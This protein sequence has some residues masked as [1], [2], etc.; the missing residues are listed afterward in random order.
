VIRTLRIALVY[1][2]KP[3]ISAQKQRYPTTEMEKTVKIFHRAPVFKRAI[4]QI[5]EVVLQHQRFD[6]SMSGEITRL[7]LNRGDSVAILLLDRSD[8]TVLLCEQFRAPTLA[9]GSGWLLE[10]PAGMVDVEENWEACARRE[11]LEELGYSAGTLR[12]IASVFLSPG[13]SSERIHVYFA[14][15]SAADAIAQG[16]GLQ[17][18]GEDIRLVRM[19][20]AEALEKAHGGEIDDAKTLIALQWL[21]LETTRRS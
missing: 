9:A 8:S 10:L 17:E 5:D 19:P 6:G 4:F 18:E 15:V 2:R 1:L 21:E 7:I 3:P 12:R 16:G 13:G 14:E 20:L 11:V